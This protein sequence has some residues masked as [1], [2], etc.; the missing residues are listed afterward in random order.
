MD[1]LPKEIALLITN[2][3]PL[4]DVLSF[5]QTSRWYANI[6]M[7]V[8]QDERK[9]LYI[10]PTRLQDVL[11]VCAH[12]QL[13]NS[14]TEIVIV[15]KSTPEIETP[16]E[17]VPDEIDVLQGEY[18]SFRANIEE[19]QRKLHLNNHPWPHIVP[20]TLQFRALPLRWNGGQEF[21]RVYYPLLQAVRSL[22]KLKAITYSGCASEGGFCPVLY[23]TIDSHAERYSNYLS[24]SM[25]LVKTNCLR[26]QDI[27]VGLML[28]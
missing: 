17:V 5:R 9:R 27:Y 16:P 25:V 13:R 18:G 24:F 23:E 20:G 28:K 26:S 19:R 11:D 22:K 4:D 7:K 6:G 15:G 10:H 21:E 14:I 1:N 12:D 8:L 2:Y 3:L